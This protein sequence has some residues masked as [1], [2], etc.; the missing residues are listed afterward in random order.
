MPRVVSIRFDDRRG[1]REMSA[2]TVRAD[3]LVG[4]RL[5]PAMT[6]SGHRRGDEID[7]P[8]FNAE[9]FFGVALVG[10]ARTGRF[11][12]PLGKVGHRK[13][14]HSAPSPC[15]RTNG[16]TYD[17]ETLPERTQP[18]RSTSSN[19]GT[20]SSQHPSAQRLSPILTK[21]QRPCPTLVF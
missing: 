2:P 9:T 20:S 19:P 21:P 6:Q 4:L 10:L 11:Y 3:T 7:L 8:V 1:P 5:C 18:R 16:V 12:S 13:A 15:F 14:G 17:V